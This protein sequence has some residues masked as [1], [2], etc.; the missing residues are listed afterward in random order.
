VI[1]QVTLSVALVTGGSLVLRSMQKIWRSIPAIGLTKWSMASMDLSILGY[2]AERGTQFYLN[3]AERV[4]NLP[5]VRS[6]EPRK[7][8]P[9]SG[10]E[11]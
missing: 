2:S 3:L 4:A 9:G 10:L 5:G 11:R 7:G 1:A 8:Q 6:G